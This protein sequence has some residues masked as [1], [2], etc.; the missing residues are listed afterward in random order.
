MSGTGRN[1]GAVGAAPS[2][3]ERRKHTFLGATNTPLFE[4]RRW[5]SDVSTTV[6]ANASVSESSTAFVSGRR[7]SHRYIDWFHTPTKARDARLRVT[8]A[9]IRV[10]LMIW[11]IVTT[12]T[13]WVAT[14]SA[15]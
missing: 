4:R 5:S 14:N 9:L 3:I 15:H 13:L 11:V 2:R 1:I 10:V 8:R 12:A 7:E 6:R